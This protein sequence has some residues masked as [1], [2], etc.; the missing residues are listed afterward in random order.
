MSETLT[1]SQQEVFELVKSKVVEVLVDLDPG[2]VTPER[3][4]VELGANSLDRVEVALL[5]ME[6]LELRIPPS[7]L[8][9]LAN[10]GELA[11]I[12]NRHR[13]AR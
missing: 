2:E 9:G 1:G 13:D 4:L 3:S 12:L 7:E 6:A 10:L 5:S 11:R 8:A